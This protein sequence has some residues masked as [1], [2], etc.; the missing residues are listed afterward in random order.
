[1]LH[2]NPVGREWILRTLPLQGL[3][4]AFGVALA[5]I[6]PINLGTGVLPPTV[7]A[8]ILGF[9]A[10]FVAIGLTMTWS[11]VAFAR[12]LPRSIELLPDEIRGTIDLR[13]PSGIRTVT[14]SIRFANVDDV[15]PWRAGGTMFGGPGPS[16]AAV[17]GEFTPALDGDRVK[18]PQTGRDKDLGAGEP[19]DILYLANENYIPV[20]KAWE[21]WK[22]DNPSNPA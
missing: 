11:R 21:V 4:V 5:L 10:V 8:S 20:R 12:T 9:G 14:R 6:W 15:K 22:R 2:P 3:F 16:P 18:L 19:F 17:F 13:G 7:A 1:M